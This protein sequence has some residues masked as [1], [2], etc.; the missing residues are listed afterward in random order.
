MGKAA[1]LVD[2]HTHLEQYSATDLESVLKR[3]GSAGVAWIVTSGMDLDTSTRAVELS[4]SQ[5]GI[6]V[7]VGIHP[8]SYTHLTLPTTPYV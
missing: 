2:V 7:S 3:A 5:S 6:A 4:R 1:R 8:V